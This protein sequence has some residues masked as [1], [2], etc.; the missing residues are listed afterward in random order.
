MIRNYLRVTPSS[1]YLDPDPI[2]S[3]LQS[4]N[5]LSEPKQGGILDRLNPFN[6]TDPVTFEF[7]AISEG[8]DDPVE[9]YYGAD[10]RLDV[11]EQRLQTLYPA[12]FD[13]DRIEID[14]VYKL[15]RPVDYD[16]SEIPDRL[17]ESRLHNP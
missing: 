17:I 8:L 3:S 16:P 13:I 9:F 12:S 4:L 6:S 7:F 10:A 14:P 2:T 11:I 5:K 15:L 1:E